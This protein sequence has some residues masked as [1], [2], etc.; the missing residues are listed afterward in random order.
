MPSTDGLE[1]F[2]RKDQLTNEEWLGLI[3]ARRSLIKPHLDTFTLPELGSLQ[4]LRSET[5]FTH[6]LN[7]DVSATI[8]DER[9]S[10]KT[11]GLFY[12][13]PWSAEERI[14][15]S[16]ACRDPGDCP[17]PDGVKRIWGLT[18]SGLWVLVTVSFVGEEG[19]KN[20]GYEK[21]YTVEIQEVDLPTIVAIT[22]EKPQKMWLKLGEAIKKWAGFRKGLYDQ[23]LGLAQ[24]VEAEELMFSL[25]PK[26]K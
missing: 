13:Q 15:N 17:C 8:G 26:A 7:L 14:P 1:G 12:E 24:A 10:L 22:K 23:A 18:R 2:V 9:F 25:I 11:Q 6:A 21:A 16:G 4:C 5:S 19:Y 20:R 3:E